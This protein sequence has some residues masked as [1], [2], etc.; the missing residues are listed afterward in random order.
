MKPAITALP[1]SVLFTLRKQHDRA[2]NS[3]SQIATAVH[4][5][6]EEANAADARVERLSDELHQAR[7]M[8]AEI[9]SVIGAEPGPEEIAAGVRGGW[10]FHLHPRQPTADGDVERLP[11]A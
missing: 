4:R 10:G 2:K 1:D 8:M 5:A 11:S 7:T 3:I 9:E 6:K